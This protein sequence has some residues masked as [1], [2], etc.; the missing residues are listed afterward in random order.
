ML[1]FGFV[2]GVYAYKDG[3]VSELKSLSDN[4][5][6]DLHEMATL[7]RIS[8]EKTIGELPSFEALT[9]EEIASVEAV[10]ECILVE[11]AYLGKY[12]GYIVIGRTNLLDQ[13]YIVSIDS[14]KYDF[15][16]YGDVV[17]IKDGELINIKDAY[18]NGLIS[19]DDAITAA[20]VGSI[21]YF[22]M[23]LN[24]EDNGL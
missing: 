15:G 3:E 7:A 8:L 14:R 16:Q 6:F 24:L 12:N 5:I 18:E 4:N 20:F 10:A 11:G 1:Q 9:A 13:N 19:K 2:N 23:V 21:H 22:N 17:M